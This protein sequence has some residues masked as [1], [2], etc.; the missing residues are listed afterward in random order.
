[1]CKRFKTAFAVFLSVALALLSACSQ[2]DEAKVTPLFKLEETAKHAVVELPQSDRFYKLL[3]ENGKI[4]TSYLEIANVTN[5][6]KNYDGRVY[7]KYNDSPFYLNPVYISYDQILNNRLI[8]AEN[9]TAA[10]EEC[11]LKAKENGFETVALYVNWWDFYNGTS[12]NFDFYKIYY[13]LAD[14]YDLNVSVIWNC[15]AKLGFMPWQTD[16]TKYPALSTVT[17]AEVPDLSQEIYVNEACEAI[18]QFC[19]W[20][21]YIDYNRRTVLIQLEDEVNTDYGKGAWLS[22]YVSF[23]NLITKMSLAVKTSHYR[24][25]TTIGYTFIDYYQDFDGF[26]G[27][28]RI[29]SLLEKDT[30]DG[31]GASFLNIQNSDVNLFN[32]NNKLCY[33]SKLSP[34]TSD[35][36]SK[37]LTLVK[38]GCMFGVYEIKSFDLAVNCGMYRTHSTDWQVR[39]TQKVD[40]G[41]LAYKGMLEAATIDVSDFIKGLNKIGPVIAEVSLLDITVFNIDTENNYLFSYEVGDTIA[42]LNNTENIPFTYNSA[43]VCVVDPYSNYYVFSFY[44]TSYFSVNCKGQLSLTAGRFSD[45]EWVNESDPIETVDNRARIS[46][47]VAYKFRIDK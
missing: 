40:R 25:V 8:S 20:L 22:Q 41:I 15:Y 7:I 32:N 29:D 36:F 47:G 33:V 9:K 24:M 1:M 19:A 39:D 34:A 5:I 35:F 43:A 46:S 42:N 45:G 27:R 6:K 3:D 17:T 10:L 23:S 37:A 28:D 2:N 30:I 14:K 12:Y 16:R 18:T 21:N 13:T 4:D 44:S 26:S 38:Q 11:F 31:I